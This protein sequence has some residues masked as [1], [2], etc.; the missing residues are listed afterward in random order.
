MSEPSFEELLNK[1][2]LLACRVWAQNEGTILD[3]EI[4]GAEVGELKAAVVVKYQEQVD[5][6]TH[7]QK[8][9]EHEVEAHQA[10]EDK[11]RAL[12]QQYN[13]VRSDLEQKCATLLDLQGMRRH[14]P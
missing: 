6:I 2:I 7:G 13:R 3:F 10:L 1:C 9:W 11:H 4:L 5:E 12:Q 14:E 8:C